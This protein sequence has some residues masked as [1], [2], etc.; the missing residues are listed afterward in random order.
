MCAHICA[1]EKILCCGIVCASTE[2]FF[3]SQSALA[4]LLPNH[5]YIFDMNEHW[6]LRWMVTVC[7]IL[8]EHFWYFDSSSFAA[9][10]GAVAVLL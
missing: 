8:C 2:L 10:A 4:T 5:K 6:T 7:Q 1:L 3:F 9:V